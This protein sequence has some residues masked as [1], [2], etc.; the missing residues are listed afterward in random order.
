MGSNPSSFSGPNRP[1]ER[2]SWTNA[3]AYCTALTV[4]ETLA[5]NVPDGY[6]YRLP[7]EA[8]W[9]YA[10]R[11]GTKTEFH[12]GQELL[13]SQAQFG[14]SNHSNTSCASGGTADV[15]G[16]APNAWGL[17][18]MHGN[19]WEWCLDT[20]A[21]HGSTPVT[22]PFVKDGQQRVYRG[23][24]WVNDSFWCRSAFRSS[25]FPVIESSGVGLRVVL[26]PVLVP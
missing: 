15:G 16:D 20:F 25:N 14:F 11:A 7:T 17:Y 26:G 5:G 6:E 4:A 22:D 8:E 9:E 3:R 24:S 12:V 19:V 2:V 18:D 23:G 21:N 10:C 13:C 1:V